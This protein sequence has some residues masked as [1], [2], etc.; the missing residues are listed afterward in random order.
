MTLRLTRVGLAILAVGLLAGAAPDEVRAQADYNV[1]ITSSAPAESVRWYE[2]HLD[3]ALS[4][5]RTRQITIEDE[6]HLRGVAPQD[7]ALLGGKCRPGRSHHVGNAPLHQT[8]QVHVALHDQNE[9]CPANFTAG[10][11]QAIQHLALAIDR[12]FR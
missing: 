1:N 4:R 6:D 9:P 12:T 8:E 11:I 7:L 3:C 2:E 5:G 10:L